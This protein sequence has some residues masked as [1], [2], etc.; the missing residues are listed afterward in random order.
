VQRTALAGGVLAAGGL[1]AACGDDDSTSNT[2]TSAS[3]GGKG[4]KGK[5]AHQSFANAAITNQVA[6]DVLKEFGSQLNLETAEFTYEG[7]SDR[8]LAQIDQMST[9]G[10][11]GVSTVILDNGI[12]RQIADACARSGLY[13]SSLAQVG[14]WVLPSEDSIN[15]HYQ[16]LATPP[17]GAYN[18]CK[19]M[20]EEVGGTGTFV[21]IQGAAGSATDAA[22]T[23]A[24]DKALKEYPGMKMVARQRGDFDREKSRVVM[25]RI[26]TAQDDDV[27]VV[28]THYDDMALGV[29]ATV[30]ERGLEGKVLIAGADALPEVVEEIAAGNIFGT[31]GIGLPVTWGWAMMQTMDVANGYKPDPIEGLMQMKLLLVDTPEAAEAYM[32]V[33]PQDVDYAKMSRVLN[34]DGWDPQWPMV[35][36]EPEQFW[37]IN[38]GV[39]K[40]AGYE[41][42]A[43]YTKR[44]EEGGYQEVDDLFADRL[45]SFPY[46]EAMKKSRSGKMAVPPPV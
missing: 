7:D 3:K 4:L 38:Q 43:N 6:F 35:H 16:G 1:L 24:V 10:V 31:E 18:L 41:L 13:L 15:W 11:T 22:K 12:T 37:A 33:K 20:F 40:P 36:F 32:K 44:V 25:D 29:L 23:K 45:T 9:A 30:R 26:L 8:E 17:D 27:D 2:Q 19:Q 42:P 39:A 28:Y 5:V 46:E 34:P 14:L 21:N